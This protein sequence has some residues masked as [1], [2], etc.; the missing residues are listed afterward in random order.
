MGR[1]SRAYRW[2]LIALGNQTRNYISNVISSGYVYQPRVGICSAVLPSISQGRSGDKHD[3]NNSFQE[4]RCLPLKFGF[5]EPQVCS[6]S[7]SGPHGQE[8]WE[9]KSIKKILIANRGEIACRVIKTA[10][11]L[12]VRTVA[13]YSEADRHAKHVAMAD[14]SVYIGP[15]PASS[16][17]L[18]GANIVATA[19]ATGADVIFL[20]V[21]IL[22]AKY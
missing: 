6:Y 18:N 5:S 8:V 1:G 16:S 13:V 15:A 4:V 19:L 22:L 7:T 17:Y 10:K 21:Q 11:K 9:G 2:A 3:A 12:G 14:E 20:S